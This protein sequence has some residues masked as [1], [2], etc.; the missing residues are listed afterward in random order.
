MKI[1]VLTSKTRCEKFTDKRQLRDDYEIVHIGQEYTD[2]E[3]LARAGDAD[4]I[5]VDAVLPVSAKLIRNM[6]KLK[7]IHSEGEPSTR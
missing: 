6:P 7:L 4:A 3:V 5:I 1:V 2:D